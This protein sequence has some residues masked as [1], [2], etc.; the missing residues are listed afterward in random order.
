MAE[1]ELIKHWDNFSQIY[2]TPTNQVWGYLNVNN[3]ISQG[4]VILDIGVGGGDESKE[5]YEKGCVVHALDISPL[6]L[7]RVKPYT[8][9]RYLPSQ[10]KELPENFFDLVIS[11]LVTQH[12]SDEDL[13]EQMKAVIKGLKKEGIFAMQFADSEIEHYHINQDIERQKSGSICRSIE[14][15]KKMVKEAGGKIVGITNKPTLFPAFKTKWHA[16]HIKKCKE[17]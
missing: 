2:N 6:G 17:K 4:K 14:K 12:M 16:I 11:H 9:E 3:F 1:E 7:E 8:I 13:L 5:L 10:L 15:M